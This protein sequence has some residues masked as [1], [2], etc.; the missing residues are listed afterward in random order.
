MADDSNS[1]SGGDE[2][3][4]EV[5]GDGFMFELRNRAFLLIKMQSP[6]V[7]VVTMWRGKEFIAPDSGN[8][9]G[10]AFRERLASAAKARFGDDAPSI[11]EDIERVA[12]ALGAPQQSG[13]RCWRSCKNPQTAPLW[14]A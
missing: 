10:K 1:K 12:T 7:A 4:M 11:T 13:K 9:F 14:I 5:K 8:I 6:T 2:L 3:K